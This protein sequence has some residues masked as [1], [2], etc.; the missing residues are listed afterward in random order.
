MQ[1]FSWK[2]TLSLE[3]FS[4]FLLP[5]FIK[6]KKIVGWRKCAF[7]HHEEKVLV[8]KEATDVTKCNFKRLFQKKN[9]FPPKDS[10]LCASWRKWVFMRREITGLATRNIRRL[11]EKPFSYTCFQILLLIKE[12]KRMINFYYPWNHQKTINYLTTS[13]WIEVNAFT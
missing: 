9:F 6:E 12:F 1:L 3:C 4:L 8:I 7:P 10:L 11:F 13:E 5:V 2:S